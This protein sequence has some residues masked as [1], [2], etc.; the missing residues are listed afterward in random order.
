MKP[1]GDGGRGL[2]FAG[3]IDRVVR[4][5]AFR[6]LERLT[7]GLGLTALL[8]RRS[9]SCVIAMAGKY[10]RLLERIV[11]DPGLPL[12]GRLELRGWEKGLVVAESLAGR[13]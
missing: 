9:A 6:A 8:D 10:R 5:E 3:P 4:Y 1:S 12:R 11:G 7:T 2:E 13:R